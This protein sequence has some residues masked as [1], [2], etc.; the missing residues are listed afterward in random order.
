MDNPS[1]KI[2]PYKS[3]FAFITA[4]SAGIIVAAALFCTLSAKLYWAF[5]INQLR[6][7]PDWIIADIFVFSF[8]EM[9]IALVYYFWH[10]KT[11]VRLM[12]LFAASICTWSV[13]NAGWLIAT[14]TQ[15]LPAVIAPLFYDPLGRFSIVGHHLAERPIAAFALLGPSAVALAF[16]FYVIAKP[17]VPQIEKKHIRAR[18]I[19]YAS[20]FFIASIFAIF[21]GDKKTPALAELRYNSQLKA[22]KS[23]F[24][25]NPSRRNIAEFSDSNEMPFAALKPITLEH[26]KYAG[27]YNIVLVVLEG[28][29]PLQ[30]NFCDGSADVPFLKKL[31][32]NGVNFTNCHT[33]ATH[34]TKAL[35]A[36]H[37]GIYPSVSQDY[38]EAAVAPA[39]CR[40]IV[41]TLKDSANYKTAFFQSAKGSFEARPGL[42]HN[43]GFDKFFAR[44]DIT[45]SNT[46]LG[47]L[48]ADEFA[49]I[50]PIE[51]WIKNSDQPFFLTVLCSATHDPYE[52]PEHYIDNE[53]NNDSKPLQRYSRLLEYTD[54]FIEE[55]YKKIISHVDKDDLIFCV[56]GDH[57]EAFGQHSRFGHARIPYEEAMKVFWI[58]SGDKI[59]RGKKIDLPVSN[60]DVT[61]TILSMLGFDISDAS[62]DGLNILQKKTNERKIYFSTWM[63]NGPAG[64]VTDNRKIIY[65]PTNQQIIEYDLSTDPLEQN[66]LFLQPKKSESAAKNV[67]LI[68][69]WQSR[70]FHIF[71]KDDTE[72][73]QRIF[74]NWLCQTATREPRAIF[75]KQ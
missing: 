64:F 70:N 54:S 67:E 37:T 7:W 44:D 63:S 40:S 55:L 52:I 35:F 38:I 3:F 51:D 19:F 23:L 53:I 68:N 49:L 48:A 72:K 9:F 66:G 50:P 29:S 20:F 18:M 34:T 56:V 17:V 25:R 69:A 57:G 74:D 8:S 16:F 28:V 21:I 13:L 27:K 32:K 26:K 47:Y 43:L 11:A 46:Y 75:D 36:I 6:N 59:K 24:Y 39:P 71:H 45:D 2:S 60:L 33:V 58:M 14:G 61:P 31:A 62:F 41:T 22:V 30:T 10:K 4:R 15:A 5:H 1:S 73:Y 65:D 12:L 42:V